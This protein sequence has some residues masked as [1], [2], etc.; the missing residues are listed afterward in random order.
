MEDVSTAHFNGLR[1]DLVFLNL[2]VG[3]AMFEIKDWSSTTIQ[4]SNEGDRTIR[5]SANQFRRDKNE[6]LELYH[7][8]LNDQLGRMAKQA[9]HAD[10]ILIK[11]IQLDVVEILSHHMP[12]D[13]RQISIILPIS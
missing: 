12:P 5:N 13:M 1:P 7:P 8:C 3:I 11:V 6:I 9:I 4:R 10:L 2:K